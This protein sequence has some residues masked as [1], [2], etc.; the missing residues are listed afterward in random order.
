MIPS[1]LISVRLFKNCVAEFVPDYISEDDHTVL[2]T[3]QRAFDNNSNIVDSALILSRELNQFD[4]DFSIII[5][6]FVSTLAEHY[7]Q[8][9]NNSDPI[10]TQFLNTNQFG[11]LSKVEDMRELQIAFK[12]I[13]RKRLKELLKAEDALEEM[14]DMRIAFQRIERKEKK[15]ILQ[16]IDQE[17]QAAFSDKVYDHSFN[18]NEL[19]HEINWRFVTRIA[20]VFILILIPTGISLFFFNT[21]TTH[22]SHN[23]K[24]NKQKENN[25][26]AEIVDITD[27]KKIDVPPMVST[28]RTAFIESSE[29]RFGFAKEEE[30]IIITCLSYNDQIVYL[31]QKIKSLE[32]KHK[33]LN[34]K[35]IKDKQSTLSSLNETEKKCALMKENLLKLESTYEFKNYHLKLVKQQK[36]D[37]KL[38]KVYSISTS[39]EQKTYYLQIGEDYFELSNGKGKLKKVID[40]E[41]LEQLLDI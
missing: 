1:D 2:N 39:V 11:F 3:L 28:Q 29:Q 22:I 33:E 35:K 26:V 12:R 14:E 21:K 8:Y 31:D 16:K 19:K 36:I 15:A 5:E 41:V 24:D 40:Q 13:E 37:L 23:E 17:Q 34:T 6:D 4:I 38:I 30:K 9:E 25:F 27:L 18:E 10:I 20:A 7:F 32:T